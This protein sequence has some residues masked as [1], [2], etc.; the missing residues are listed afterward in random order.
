MKVLLVNAGVYK[1]GAVQTLTN[2]IILEHEKYAKDGLELFFY[3]SN[4][5][6]YEINK[7]YRKT[8]FL[9]CKIL[10]IYKFF[11]KLIYNLIKILKKDKALSHRMDFSALYYIN[12]LKKYLRKIDFDLIIFENYVPLFLALKNRKLYEKYKGKYIY[13]VHNKPTHNA[14]CKNII[15]NSSAF[16]CISKY[17][18]NCITSSDSKIG[19]VKNEKIRIFKNCIDTNLFRPIVAF[20]NPIYNNF[21]SRDEKIILFAGR[22]S[23]EKGIRETILAFNM[24]KNIKVRLVIVGTAFYGM[25]LKMNYEKEIFNLCK[26]NK[27]ISLTGFVEYENM[28]YYYNMADVIVLPSIWEE[29]A[30]MTMIEAMSCGKTIITTNVGGIKEYTEDKAILVNN[31]SNIVENLH[32]EIMN[33]LNNPKKYEKFGKKAREHIIANYSK[34]NYYKKFLELVREQD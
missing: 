13:H 23:P 1:K 22:I 34:E 14:G 10:K 30:G 26:N 24:I 5:E 3:S 18:A 19:K 15:L 6:D 27:Q 17:V 29:P 9:Y 20:E 21:H 11:D 28:P 32:K 31:N 12:N 33:V 2:T 4:I 25:K 7:K 8:N 16:Y